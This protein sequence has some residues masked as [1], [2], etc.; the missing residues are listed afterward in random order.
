[1]A[2]PLIADEIVRALKFEG[3]R[4]VEHRDWRN[5]NRNH[6]GP[7]GPVHGIMIHH[8]VTSGTEATVE[9]CYNGR[10]DLPGPL[11]LGVIAK[12]GT[13][14]LVGNGRANHAGLGDGDVLRA[15]IEES[16]IPADNGANTDGNAHF[17]GFECVNMGDGKDPW[18]KEQ[19]DAIVKAST[20]LSRAHGWG[21]GSTIGHL[22]WQPGKVDPRPS[23]GGSDVSM[24]NI[25]QRIAEE[26]K[27]VDEEMPKRIVVET[28]DFVHIV[29][30]K[31][32]TR[33]RF[34]RRFDGSWEDQNNI[35][36]IITGAAYYS[37]SAAV[38]V[39][40]MYSGQEFQIRFAYYRKDEDGDWVRFDSLPPSSPTHESMTARLTHSWNGFVPEDNNA[41]VYCEVF[42][43]GETPVSVSFA[44]VEGL[45][46]RS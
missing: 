34:N 12:D 37:L 35:A 26:L 40:G 27:G 30:P 7:W 29:E 8:T 11:C 5:N 41:R 23:P 24:A 25:R 38:S 43:M 32:W 14:H 20:A 18:P 15:V 36:T 10:P 22:E 46:W 6:K 4:V 44:R 45:V 28:K 21:A 2:T 31:T 17:Y 42:H 19:V 16:S 39:E 33:L 3:L 13:V 9:L 1:M